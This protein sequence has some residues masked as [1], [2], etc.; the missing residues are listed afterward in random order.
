MTD[1]AGM[2]PFLVAEGACSTLSGPI[3][4]IFLEFLEIWGHQL[5]RVVSFSVE[6]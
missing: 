6:T 2:P 1:G 3:F 5:R 4:E